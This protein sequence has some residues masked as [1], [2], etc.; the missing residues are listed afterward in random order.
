MLHSICYTFD[1]EQPQKNQS[2]ESTKE[3]EEREK[4]RQRRQ[5][6]RQ[7]QEEHVGGMLIP[8]L[9]IYLV[10]Y[11]SC[12]REFASQGSCGTSHACP[13]LLLTDYTLDYLGQCGACYCGNLC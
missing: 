9:F 1:Q 3:Q 12:F 2:E 6:A 5:E 7:E 13:C 4:R 11:F 10:S 8:L